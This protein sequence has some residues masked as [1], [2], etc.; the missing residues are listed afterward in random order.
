MHLK[1]LLTVAMFC[2]AVPLAGCD[3][4]NNS[5]RP[6]PAAHSPSSATGTATGSPTA[7]AAATDWWEA[8]LLTEPEYTT[9]VVADEQKG[10]GNTR[11][12]AFPSNGKDPIRVVVACSGIGQLTLIVNKEKDGSRV[13]CDQVRT[14]I[15]VYTESGQQ[16]LTL[17]SGSEIRWKVA[18]IRK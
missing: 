11:L 14:F 15:D 18:V 17:R 13:Q 16:H 6:D 9:K 10:Q 4:S 12:P 2:V 5:A 7:T 1:R 8:P 3:G